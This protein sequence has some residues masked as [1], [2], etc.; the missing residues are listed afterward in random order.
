MAP[1]A[2]ISKASSQSQR[3]LHSPFI[4]NT[5]GDDVR[6]PQACGKSHGHSVT[7]HLQQERLKLDMKKFK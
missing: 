5:S 2:G 1:H 7:V 4:L 6:N 3:A